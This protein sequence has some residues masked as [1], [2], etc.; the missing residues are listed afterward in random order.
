MAYSEYSNHFLEQILEQITDFVLT[1]MHKRINTDII[2]KDFQ[3]AFDTL[4]HKTLLENMSCPH[5][6][7]PVIEW[8]ESVL[9]IK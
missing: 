8:F 7:T 4:T 2:L 9:S 6:K 5:F 1:G 3:K